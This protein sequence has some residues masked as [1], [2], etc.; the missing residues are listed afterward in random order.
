MVSMRRHILLTAAVLWAVSC[1]GAAPAIGTSN[2]GA[3]L[4]EGTQLETASAPSDV[5]LENGVSLRLSPQSAGT[6]FSDHM[7]LEEG[8][9]HVGNFRGFTIDAGRLQIRGNEPGAQAAVRVTSKTVEIASIGGSLNVTDGGAMLT[10]VVS[11]TRVSFQQS[12]ASPAQ[13]GAA[14]GHRRL[15]SDQHIMVWLIGITAAAALAIGLTAAAQGK[16]PF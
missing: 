2:G 16:S 14:P 3:P 5:S 10:R 13:T 6:V 9:A 4:L 11:G 12:A 15:P 1:F 8:S 7:V